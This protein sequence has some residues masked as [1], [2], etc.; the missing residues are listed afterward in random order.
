MQRQV[1]HMGHIAPEPAE[2]EGEAQIL[3]RVYPAFAVPKKLM[4][5]SSAAIVSSGLI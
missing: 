1:H 2:I 3:G 5:A 4:T